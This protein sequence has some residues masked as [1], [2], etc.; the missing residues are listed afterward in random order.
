MYFD[1]VVSIGDYVYTSSL[2]RDYHAI[3]FLQKI[4]NVV[5]KIRCPYRTKNAALAALTQ[6]KKNNSVP[7]PDYRIEYFKGGEL[8]R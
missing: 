6:L 4:G 3:D 7:V 8:C 5:V 2:W 1:N